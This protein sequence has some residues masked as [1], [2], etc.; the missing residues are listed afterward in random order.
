[1]RGAAAGVDPDGTEGRQQKER[2]FFDCASN[3]HQF[4]GSRARCAKKQNMEADKC[5]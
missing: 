4:K 5:L 3:E 1:M 2:V